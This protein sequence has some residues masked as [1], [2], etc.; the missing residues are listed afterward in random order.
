[1]NFSIP[2]YPNKRLEVTFQILSKLCSWIEVKI[3]LNQ[4]CNHQGLYTVLSLF[5]L[6]FI[7]INIY[8]VRHWNYEAKRFSTNEELYACFWDSRDEIP[9]SKFG[10]KDCDSLINDIIR[11]RPKLNRIFISHVGNSKYINEIYYEADSS[12]ND[13]EE[14]LRKILYPY[15]Q[16]NLDE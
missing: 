13:C 7:E 10:L 14:R 2:V 11:I 1:M 4:D 12:L 8:D 15:T 5:K 6:F 3:R 16:K 9:N